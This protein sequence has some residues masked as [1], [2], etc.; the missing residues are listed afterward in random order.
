M[1]RSPAASDEEIDRCD[2]SYTVP[3]CDRQLSLT[4]PTIFQLPMRWILLAALYEKRN[5]PKKV[6]HNHPMSTVLST[7]PK[8]YSFLSFQLANQCFLWMQV[9]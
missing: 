2:N 5:K 1:R 9:K 3:L 6:P 4:T 7:I 8:I